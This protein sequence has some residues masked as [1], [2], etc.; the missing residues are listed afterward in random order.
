MAWRERRKRA[1][2]ADDFDLR[3]Q[4]ADRIGGP[5]RGG[6]RRREPGP[7]TS[8][9]ARRGGKRRFGIGRLFYWGAVLTLW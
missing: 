7:R 2:D 1:G 9:K 8:R 4:S 5:P 3:L 6:N